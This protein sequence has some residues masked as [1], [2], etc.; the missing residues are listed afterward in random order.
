MLH[1]SR[2]IQFTIFWHLTQIYMYW[3]P[4]RVDALSRITEFFYLR[5]LLLYLIFRFIAHIYLPNGEYGRK[6]FLF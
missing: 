3:T 4:V 2:P 5:Q 1:V 6:A